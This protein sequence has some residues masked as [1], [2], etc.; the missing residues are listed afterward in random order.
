MK[1][2]MLVCN[3]YSAWAHR[4]EQNTS[5]HC[6]F[7]TICIAI[8]AVTRRVSVV[9]YPSST[10][11][12][13]GPIELSCCD[14]SG[15]RRSEVHAVLTPKQQKTKNSKK[16]NKHKP[17]KPKLNKQKHEK[18]TNKQTTKHTNKQQNKQKQ[19]KQN[20]TE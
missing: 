11:D 5:Q 14:A 8:L 15:G 18:Q 3:N 10:R 1:Y 12:C 13:C 20:P 2:L 17:G 19:K 16:S 7:N 9:A 6:D 4:S